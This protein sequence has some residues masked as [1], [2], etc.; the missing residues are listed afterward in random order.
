MSAEETHLVTGAAGFAGR[1]LCRLL[2]GHGHRVIAMRGPG[3]RSDPIEGAHQ[4][5]LQDLLDLEGLAKVLDSVKPD[6]LYHLAAIANVGGSWAAQKRTHETNYMGTFHLLESIRI[7]GLKPRIALV[8]S[9]AAYGI[10]RPPDRPITESAPLRPKDPYGASKAA[11]EFLG[12]QFHLSHGLHVVL[13]RPF[14]HTGPGQSP[15]FVCA[16]FSRQIAAIELGL[17]KPTIRVGNLEAMRDFTDVRDTVEAY[18]LAAEKCEA[19][20]PYN[21]ATGQAWSISQVLERL[22]ELA[23]VPVEVEVD[24]ALFRPIDNPLMLGDASKLRKETGWQPTKDF[25]RETLAE[26]LEDWRARLKKELQ[27]EL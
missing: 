18:R 25:M 1:H 9:A 14:N 23:K 12:L 7:A 11:A 21:I 8:G 19:G 4:E 3:S 2:R 5:I 24:P 6:S 17:K 16:D 15:G 10:A 27:G 13:L 22:C 20:I 26:L